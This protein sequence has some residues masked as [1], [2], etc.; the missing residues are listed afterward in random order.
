[1]LPERPE[2]VATASLPVTIDSL[3]S[4]TRSP[5]LGE[6]SI[7]TRLADANHFFEFFMRELRCIRSGTA[8]GV[9]M[10]MAC[11]VMVVVEN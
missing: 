4:V 1:M 5:M 3:S 2:F 9:A 7:G 6:K 11:V 8:V 10:A